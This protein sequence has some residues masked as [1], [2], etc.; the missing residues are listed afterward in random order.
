M[1]I[2][3]RSLLAGGGLILAGAFTPAWA[4]DLEGTALRAAMIGKAARAALATGAAP[5]L[6]VA[7]AEQGKLLLA[8][9]FGAANL[10]T[11][12]IV[13]P[14]SVFRIGSLSK[15]FTA[16]AA[17]KLAAA[18]KLDLDSPVDKLL[19]AFAGKPAFSLREAMHHTAGLHSDEGGALPDDGKPI[20]QVRLAEAIAAQHQ[21]TD[22]AP[23]TA[24]LYSNANYI[25]LGAAIEVA[26][27]MPFDA[28][29]KDLLFRPLGLA[30]TAVDRA[31]EVVAR[32]VS[33]YT[34]DDKATPPGWANAAWLDIWQAGGAGAI[35][36]TVGDLARWHQALLGGKIV[37]RSALLAP[38][39]LRD[40]R[41]SGAN[42]FS[43]E[44]AHYGDVQYAGGLLVTPASK[45]PRVVQH[46]GF[47]SGFSA[48]L[49]TEL[50]RMRTLVVLLNC[51]P[52][53]KLPFHALRQAAFG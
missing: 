50:D 53:P 45:S 13:A 19:P 43:P 51:D 32:R 20:S 44:D 46:Y 35:R 16:A 11:S 27:R 26:A 42:R 40:G 22:F 39:R 48:L 41:L 3:R 29:M 37:D 24:W 7:V 10:E 18:G 28:A 17:L 15:Q 47:I 12:T 25:V 5:G 4:S 31:D 23:G 9:G 49:E 8:R 1:D 38:G 2:D 52:G 14:D 36:S 33:G 6:A 21:L 34:P 30:S